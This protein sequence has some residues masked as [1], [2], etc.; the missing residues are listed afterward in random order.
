MK[1]NLSYVMCVSV[2]VKMG[3]PVD[4]SCNGF[5]RWHLPKGMYLDNLDDEEI[6][7]IQDKINNRPRMLLGHKT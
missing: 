7:L 4:S 3:A 2:F 6:T 1:T 5:I